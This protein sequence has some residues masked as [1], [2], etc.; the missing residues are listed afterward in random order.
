MTPLPSPLLVVTERSPRHAP[1]EAAQR[2]LGTL[3]VILA[4]GVR[5][6]WFRERDLPEE[7]REPLA[8]ATARVVRAGRGVLTIGGDAALAARLGADG[9][10]LA[11]DS[12]GADLARA[13]AFLPDG[14]L[15]LSAHGLGD[16]ERAAR[17]GAD[18]VTLSPIFAS[19]SKPGYG[20]ALGL[21]ALRDATRF[22]L[23]ILALGGMDPGTIRAS[24]AAGAAGVAVM[25]GIM[26]ADDA[27]SAAR[28]HLIAAEAT[29]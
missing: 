22:G 12:T 11:G 26:R 28:D 5:W 1:E 10:H 21:D 6:V 2:L 23:P 16:V 13:R 9:V 20:P 27:H 17:G 4:A 7:R 3:H 18:Y 24:R 25:G 8:E 15:G 14:L 19:A 29:A